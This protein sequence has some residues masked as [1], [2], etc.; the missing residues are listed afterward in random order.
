[1][2]G[3]DKSR[4]LIMHNS[5]HTCGGAFT[6]NCQEIYGLKITLMLSGIS[7]LLVFGSC[8]VVSIFMIKC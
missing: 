7:L 5:M 1:M 8:V 2:Y 3:E 4:V 6:F